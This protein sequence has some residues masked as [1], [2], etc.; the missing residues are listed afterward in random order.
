MGSL[1]TIRLIGDDEEHLATVA[2]AALDEIDRVERLLSWRDPRSECA[3]INREAVTGPVLVD[4]EMTAIL[5]TCDEAR[6]ATQGYFD[7]TTGSDNPQSAITNPQSQ[8][9]DLSFEIDPDTRLV[10]FSAPGVRLDFGAFGKGYA[11]DRA[12][13][14]MRRFGVTH[15]LLDGGTSSILA[16]GDGPDGKPWRV[17]LRNPFA[18]DAPELRQLVLCDAALS[19]S[20]VFDVETRQTSDVVDPHTGRPLADAAAVAVIANSAA[21]AEVLSTALLSMGKDGARAETEREGNSL[22]AA[23]SLIVW[24]EPG[25][26]AAVIEAWRGRII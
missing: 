15:A 2:E 1:F 4:H 17:G 20:G 16:V 12:A 23:A 5:Q 7:I 10:R 25:D 9:S 22:I 24:M 8:I 18:A 26:G 11:L 14:E 13:D 19:C 21:T 6:R 3:R